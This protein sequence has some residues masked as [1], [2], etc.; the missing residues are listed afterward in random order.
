MNPEN[1]GRCLE[2]WSPTGNSKW[3]NNSPPQRA[4]WL[5]NQN[6][7]KGKDMNGKTFDSLWKDHVFDCALSPL[8]QTI[9][10]ISRLNLGI[11]KIC[12]MGKQTNSS[13]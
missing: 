10:L 9:S 13:S 4:F 3:I 11:R 12:C 6:Y 1:S 7:I 8:V 5:Q 2:A